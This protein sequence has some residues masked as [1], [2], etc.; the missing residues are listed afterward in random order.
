MINGD[1]YYDDKKK[2]GFI[3]SLM[4]KGEAAEWKEQF[5]KSKTDPT[6]QVIT[7]PTHADFIKQVRDDFKQEDQVGNTVIKLKLLKQ[8][9]D[10][11]VE[12]LVTKF[13]LLVGQ[14]GLGSTTASDQI[15]LIEMFKKP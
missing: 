4:S 9:K 6:T 3:L 2:T 7:L 5:L 14:A 15:H 8:G 13:R 12:G 1:V 10:Q 11:N